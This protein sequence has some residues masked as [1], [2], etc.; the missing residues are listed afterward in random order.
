MAEAVWR[1]KVDLPAKEQAAA[2]ARRVLQQVLSSW[3]RAQ[4]LEDAGIVASELVTN[5]VQHAANGGQLRLD[6][7]IDANGRL[8]IAVNDGSDQLPTLQEPVVDAEAG[9][10]LR[11][12][13]QLSSRWGV[14]PRPGRGK[15]VWAELG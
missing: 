6:V 12:V 9:R 4:L 5:A 1:L 15:R 13:A 7:E 8:S 3:G 11:I 2:T 14:E 10:G